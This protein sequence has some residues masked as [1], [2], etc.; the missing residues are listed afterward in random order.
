VSA[1]PGPFERSAQSDVGSDLPGV[2]V[3]IPAYNAEKYVGQAV[4]SVLAQTAPA[5]EVVVVDD[6]STDGTA[7]VLSRYPAPVRV[8]RLD[9]GGVARARNVGVEATAARW[10]AFLDAD[11]VWVPTYLEQMLAAASARPDAAL[12]YCGLVTV[13]ADL[14]PLSRR[15]VPASVV[16][17]RNTLVLE[18]PVVSVAQGAL[19]KREAFVAISGF[20][21]EMSTSADT[22][23]VVRL[24]A[25]HPVVAVDDYLVLYRQHGAQMSAGVDAMLRDMTR[26]YGKVFDR[27]MLPSDLEHLR[28]RAWANLHLAVGGELLSRGARR[29]AVSHLVAAARSDPRRVSALALRSLRRRRAT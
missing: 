22:D 27:G 6:G 14:R 13:D 25:R 26:C 2:A 1:S 7:A 15:G 23:L 10:V 8:V 18:P 16:A 17:L 29:S 21:E 3:V 5:M 11:D 20:D 12:V 24:A 28:G 19:V 4:D 9:N